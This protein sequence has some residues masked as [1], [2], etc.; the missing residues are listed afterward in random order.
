MSS[1]HL[2]Q[3]R[4]DAIRLREGG[5]TD[6]AFK[7]MTEFLSLVHPSFTHSHHLFLAEI[8]FEKKKYEEALKECDIAISIMHDFIPALE[9]RAKIFIINS[10]FEKAELDRKKIRNIRDIEKAKWDDPDHYYHYK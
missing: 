10:E 4:E 8:Y 5:F 6:L 1:D 2:I 7:K 9:L 3:L